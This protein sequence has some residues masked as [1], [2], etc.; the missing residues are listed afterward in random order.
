LKFFCLVFNFVNSVNSVKNQ[1][2]SISFDEKMDQACLPWTGSGV[3]PYPTGA[4]ESH[5]LAD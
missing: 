4:S 5:E 2:H 3:C 1:F